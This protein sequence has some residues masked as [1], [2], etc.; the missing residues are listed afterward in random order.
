MDDREAKAQGLMKSWKPLT[1]GGREYQI[2]AMFPDQEWSILG[3]VKIEGGT[4]IMCAW[5]NNGRNLI[6]GKESINDL[7]PEEPARHVLKGWVN[8]YHAAVTQGVVFFL[9]GYETEADAKRNSYKGV[10]ARK[11]INIEYLEGEG[12]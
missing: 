3:A 12:L 4:W 8:L 2:F 10:K 9:V 6:G 5:Q 7:L 11:L 1:R